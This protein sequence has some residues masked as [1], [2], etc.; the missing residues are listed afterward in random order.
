MGRLNHDKGIG[1]L[2]EAFNKL[3]TECPQAKLVLYGNDEENYD[4]TINLY[5]NIHRGDNYFY[6]GKTT[7]P[8]AALQAGDVFVLP[9]WREGFGITG[10]RCKVGNSESLYEAMK[11]YYFDPELRKQHGKAGRQRVIEKFDN[12]IVSKAWI[13]YYHELLNK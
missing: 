6:P 10:L 12:A 2:Y 7:M 13:D 9:T 3:V 4:N 1:E 8:F 5:E 11:Q